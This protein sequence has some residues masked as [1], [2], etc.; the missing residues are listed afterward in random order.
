[1]KKILFKLAAVL[2]AVLTLASCGSSNSGTEGA[3]SVVEAFL[4]D[5]THSSL[6]ESSYYFTDTDK[7]NSE[8]SA[9]KDSADISGYISTAMNGFDKYLP[10]SILNDITALAMGKIYS[11]SIEDILI[12]GDSAN[13]H[14]HFRSMDMNSINAAEEPDTIA[15]AKESFGFDISDGAELFTRYLEKAGMTK[16]EFLEQYPKLSE[17]E[18]LKKLYTPFRKEMLDFFSKII[19]KQYENA[20]FNEM[21]LE[22]NLKQQSDGSWKIDNLKQN[23]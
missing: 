22:F 3:K 2:T 17:E 10:T 6:K 9:L 20:Q 11:Y 14:A 18:L 16:E 15:L 21:K 13:V 19:D 5:F 12:N 23:K 1:M 4:A 7:N 8:Y